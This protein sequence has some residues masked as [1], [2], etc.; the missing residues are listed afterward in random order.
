MSI[1][2]RLDEIESVTAYLDDDMKAEVLAAT[3]AL[4]AVFD[5]HS[6][7]E[8]CGNP[9]C[10]DFCEQCLESWPC[11]TVLAIEAALG[12]EH[13]IEKEATSDE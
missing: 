6:R 5:L 11:P 7:D 8:G 3:A 9:N 10:C 1:S 12:M 2:D 4:R 13:V